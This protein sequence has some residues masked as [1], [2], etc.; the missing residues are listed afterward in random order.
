M[1]ELF[2]DGIAQ[3]AQ[4]GTKGKHGRRN[5]ACRYNGRQIEGLL[6]QGDEKQVFVHEAR[7]EWKQGN[8]GT[9]KLKK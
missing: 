1:Q 6:A 5:L 3:L 2:A 9:K 4:L 8:G 7:Q